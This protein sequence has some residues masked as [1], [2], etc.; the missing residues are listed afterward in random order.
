MTCTNCK[1]YK[2]LRKPRTNCLI[3]FHK[4]CAVQLKKSKKSGKAV[5]TATQTRDH[6]LISSAKS[7]ERIDK[8]RLPPPDV[9]IFDKKKYI[10]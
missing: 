10:G 4:F 8:L 3:C 1:R 2:G 6:G 7:L 9:A 5:I